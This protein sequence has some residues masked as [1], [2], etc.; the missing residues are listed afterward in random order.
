[1][2]L[3][4]LPSELLDHIIS[5][6]DWN[7]N[8]DLTPQRPSLLCASLACKLLREAAVP[9]IFR[10]VTLRLRWANHVLL[11][12]RVILIRKTPYLARYVRA[13]YIVVQPQQESTNDV[14]DG[15]PYQEYALPDESHDWLSPAPLSP[16]HSVEDH[17]ISI[18]TD[19]R[20]RVN[21]MLVS[22]FSA[23]ETTLMSSSAE[24]VIHRIAMEPAQDL[25]SKDKAIAAS[26]GELGH[27]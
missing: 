12:P 3:S 1:M 22:R 16:L 26:L 11:E 7:P 24:K 14:G 25:I 18:N 15:E 10:T 17:G 9:S 27:N 21:S 2:P 5:Y 6:L 8:Q 4:A 23:N 13:V 19:H 20:R